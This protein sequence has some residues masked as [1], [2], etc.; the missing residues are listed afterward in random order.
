MFLE[1]LAK[2]LNPSFLTFIK[3][4]IGQLALA[5][6]SNV[7]YLL[8]VPI[9]K[10]IVTKLHW[11]HHLAEF[12]LVFRCCVR[13]RVCLSLLVERSRY[14]QLNDQEE[15]RILKPLTSLISFII[16]H[17]LG[18]MVNILS[19]MVKVHIHLKRP[20]IGRQRSIRGLP[21]ALIC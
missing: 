9:I 2:L 16:E 6:A 5:G 15:I 11:A 17:D 8:Q 19:I 10:Q 20:Q 18:S 1:F 7:N 3:M 13:A 12:L 14:T 21:F 4:V